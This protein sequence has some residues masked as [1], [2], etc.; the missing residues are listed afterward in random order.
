MKKPFYG[1]DIWE[2][3]IERSP[4]R[5]T[6]NACQDCGYRNR[7]S[8]SKDMCC[9]CIFGHKGRENRKMYK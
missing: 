9:T 7:P 8:M 2:R 6:E 4:L 3:D 1:Q 5:Y